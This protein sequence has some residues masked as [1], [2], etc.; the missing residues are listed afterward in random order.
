MRRA[1]KRASHVAWLGLL[2]LALISQPSSSRAGAWTQERGKGLVITTVTISRASDAFDSSGA[3]AGLRD[4]RK[5][6]LKS[7]VEYGL[8][9]GVTL[10]L[11]PTAQIVSDDAS[12]TPQKARGL[13][14]VDLGA[15]L[16]LF[17]RG[18]HVFSVEPHVIL[19]GTL[20]NDENVL[21]AS[22]KTDFELRAL[23][24]LSGR[25]F[26]KPFFLNGEGAYRR[27][28]GVFPDEVRVDVSTGISPTARWQVIAKQS[29]IVSTE[30][31]SLHKLGGSLVY[32]LSQRVSLETGLMRAIAGREVVRENV[33]QMG[34]WVRF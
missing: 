21:L 31:F 30:R 11:A 9:T 13:A 20:D 18:A 15:R 7:Y 4:F 2:L 32:H 27:R 25:A 33:Y 17:T 28:G 22:G 26:N 24:G 34:I 10:L 3:R 6:E 8:R 5:N 12:G 14:D 16:R 19:P 29:S 1:T 23:Y